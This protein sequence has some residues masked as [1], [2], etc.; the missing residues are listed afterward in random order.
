MAQRSSLPFAHAAIGHGE[1]QRA[2]AHHGP[3]SACFFAGS[4]AQLRLRRLSGRHRRKAWGDQHGQWRKEPYLAHR[5]KW[6]MI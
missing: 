2:S 1:S 4:S 5:H 3:G 6:S